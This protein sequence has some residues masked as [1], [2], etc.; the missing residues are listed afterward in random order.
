MHRGQAKQLLKQGECSIVWLEFIF[1]D[2]I[3]RYV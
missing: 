1:S 2:F 3:D